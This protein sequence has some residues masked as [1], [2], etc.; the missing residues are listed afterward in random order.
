MGSYDEQ[1]LMSYLYVK[2]LEAR[3]LF[4][5]HSIFLPFRSFLAVDTALLAVDRKTSATWTVKPVVRSTAD[6][7]MTS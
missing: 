6:A 1:L 2:L 3:M 4:L 5:M 7:L